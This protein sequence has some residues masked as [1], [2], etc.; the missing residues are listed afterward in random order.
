MQLAIYLNEI[1]LAM[2][3][4]IVLRACCVRACVRACDE[5]IAKMRLPLYIISLRCNSETRG[6]LFMESAHYTYVQIHKMHR[7]CVS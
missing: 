6:N 3:A 4:R 1:L 7:H 2:D 5:I